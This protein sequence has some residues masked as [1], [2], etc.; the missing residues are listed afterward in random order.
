MTEIRKDHVEWAVIDRLRQMLEDPP[1]RR[2]SVTEAYALFTTILCWVMQHLRI[3]RR[4]VTNTA[5]QAAL[6]LYARLEDEPI[7]RAPWHMHTMSLP[8]IAPVVGQALTIPASYGFEAHTAGRFLK[9]LR[10]ATAHGGTRN[11]QPFN[12]LGTLLGFTFEC[13][14]VRGRGREREVLW[15][16]EITLLQ[17]DMQR[18]GAELARRYC[19]VVQKANEPRSEADFRNDAAIVKETAA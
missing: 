5:D 14:E 12:R 8:R 17:S 1:C 15:R 10:D 7:S 18:L 13:E 4:S 2:F 3:Q 6:Q 16:G 19:G 11:I 9:N